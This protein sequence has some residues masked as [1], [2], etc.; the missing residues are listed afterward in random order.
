ME[1]SQVLGLPPRVEVTALIP[2]G[3]PEEQGDE[4]RH[5]TGRKKLEEMVHWDKFT[6]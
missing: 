3:Y 1:C 5:D 6:R 2:L 4:N